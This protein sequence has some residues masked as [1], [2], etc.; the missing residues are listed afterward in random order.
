MSSFNFVTFGEIVPTIRRRTL[1]IPVNSFQ[2][3]ARKRNKEAGRIPNPES[4]SQRRESKLGGKKVYKKKKCQ[5]KR[6]RKSL[7]FDDKKCDD[8][9]VQFNQ[10]RLKIMSANI[11]EKYQ[12]RQ[13]TESEYR[14]CDANCLKFFKGS[15]AQWSRDAALGDQKLVS[16]APGMTSKNG[17]NQWEISEREK[18]IP[19]VAAEIPAFS[20]MTFCDWKDTQKRS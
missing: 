4:E 19:M 2:K 18:G 5:K 6:E 14:K 13:I 15:E 17:N 8:W 11:S 3:A 20:K 10:I 16:I 1:S 7:T 9:V 12:S